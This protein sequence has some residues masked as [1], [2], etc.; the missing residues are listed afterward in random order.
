M[1][2]WIHL[3][4]LHKLRHKYSPTGS[5]HFVILA[6]DGTDQV[7]KQRC[8]IGKALWAVD[9]SIKETQWRCDGASLFLLSTNQIPG[10]LLIDFTF[11]YSFVRVA[12]LFKYQSNL[13]KIW[14]P[15]YIN[16]RKES[17]EWL[18]SLPWPPGFCDFTCICFQFG[19][20]VNWI[21]FKDRNHFS[22]P[23]CIPPHCNPI[24]ISAI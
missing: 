19:Y 8:R 23:L 13:H 2:L 9:F 1:T 18:S 24:W 22:L 6:W 20:K 3:Q 16:F 17:I 5:P 14:M 7:D 15:K 10:D 12:C 4:I 21:Y 11:G